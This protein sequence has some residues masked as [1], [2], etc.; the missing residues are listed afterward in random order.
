MQKTLPHT[1]VTKQDWIDAG[2]DAVGEVPIDR[3]RI[4]S[5]A[6]SLAVSR[7][8]F[9]WYFTGLDEL[10]H[11]LL[12]VWERNTRSIVERAHRQA[13]TAVAA[14]L[15]VFE[16][17]ADGDLYDAQLDLA[18]RDWGRR[19]PAVGVRIASADEA[20]L[21]ALA[22]M[23]GR[24]GFDTPECVVR[25]RLLYHSQVG[26]YAAG[27]DDSLASRLGYL[28]YYLEAMAG[29]TP[30]DKELRAFENFLATITS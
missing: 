8:S 27:T 3:L 12:E 14:C 20:R 19:D 15:G 4:L 11:E 25:A 7:S 17:W 13:A 5:L 22:V 1:K 10:L 28:P 18:V 30:T 2:L 24:Y 16:C 9:Y 29:K 23:F 26:Y 6:K 21:E